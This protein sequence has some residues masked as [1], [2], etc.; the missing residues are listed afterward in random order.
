MLA[1]RMQSRQLLRVNM[2]RRS[3]RVKED[4]KAK[5]KARL[6]IRKLSPMS[7]THR[8]A[9]KQTIRFIQICI[10]EVRYYMRPC[11]V[12]DDIA[13]SK[14]PPRVTKVETAIGAA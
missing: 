1:T 5:E 8:K 2:C 6:R 9:A 13:E 4:P 7:V 10:C 3:L 11:Y 14:P 12:C